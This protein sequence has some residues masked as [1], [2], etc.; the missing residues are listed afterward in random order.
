VSSVTSGSAYIGTSGW[1]YQHWRASVYPAHV[2]QSEWLTFLMA[3]L[4]TVE[5]NSSFYRLPKPELMARWNELARPGF[6]FALKMWRGISHYSKLKDAGQNV[7][8]FLEVAELLQPALRGPLLL[9]LPP[10]QRVDTEKLAAFLDHWERTVESRWRLAVE[11]RHDSWLTPKVFTILDSHRSAVCLHDMTG[12]GAIS[13][14]NRA[15]FVYVRRHG[16]GEALYGGSYSSQQL[17]ADAA[18]IR[19]WIREGRDVYL[20]FNND[21]GGHAFHNALALKQRLSSVEQPVGTSSR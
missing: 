7:A 6:T 12:R 18:H 16:P 9:Q 13:K 14:P 17:D 4:D 15:P 21:I 2:R 20:Y 10:S 1:S 5:V 3:Q 11:F 19:E 8:R